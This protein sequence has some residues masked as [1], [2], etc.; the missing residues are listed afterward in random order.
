MSGHCL[1]SDAGRFSRPTRA[2]RRALR[3]L[4][5]AYRPDPP[6]RHQ[7]DREAEL[8]FVGL[9]GMID[10]PRE[11]ARV[12]VG[13]CREAGIRPVMITGDHPATALAVAGELGMVG[14][15]DRAVSG[16]ELESMTD[17]QLAEQVEQIPSMPACP[18][19]T[20]CG[21]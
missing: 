12:A 4:A 20:S 10:P 11:E 13:R 2:W 16:A 21:S 9:V 17:D 3:V 15:E 14:P 7:A 18:P 5:L 8:V 1:P 6:D 19:N